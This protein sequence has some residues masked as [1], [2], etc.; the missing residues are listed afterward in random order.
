MSTL[1]RKYNTNA[2]T[3][4]FRDMG[5]L[6]AVHVQEDADNFKAIREALERIDNKLTPIADSY[7][8][9]T[10]MCKWIMGFLV[11]VSIIVGIIAALRGVK[12]F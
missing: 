1:K 2:P 9:A 11:F 10:T 5:K 4:E 7:M 6:F 8:A 12:L 3:Q